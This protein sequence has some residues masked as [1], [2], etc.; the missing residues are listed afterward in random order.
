VLLDGMEVSLIA[1]S[2]V[3]TIKVG[4]ELAAQL[5]PRGEHSLEYVHEP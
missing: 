5:L 2:R 1:R 3:G 4:R